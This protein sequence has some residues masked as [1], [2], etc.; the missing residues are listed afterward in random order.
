MSG[1]SVGQRSISAQAI[2]LLVP[3]T[4]SS[5]IGALRHLFPLPAPSR[6]RRSTATPLDC[7]CQLLPLWH[8]H[9]QLTQPPLHHHHT[10][11]RYPAAPPPHPGCLVLYERQLGERP[12]LGRAAAL[13]ACCPPPPTALR[14]LGPACGAGHHP[15][16]PPVTGPEPVAL[17][18]PCFRGW[19]PPR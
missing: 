2:Q 12:S 16:S 5:Y 17:F 19:V 6:F 14:L 4:L 18:R 13:L 10:H 1:S 15:G 7:R 11:R 3:V 9:L 8:L